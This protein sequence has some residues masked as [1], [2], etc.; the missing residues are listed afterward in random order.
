MLSKFQYRK[1][2]S[3]VKINV[4]E[5][6]RIQVTIQLQLG[7]LRRDCP[8]K[9][10]PWLHRHW[11]HNLAPIPG[12]LSDLGHFQTFQVYTCVQGSQST[13]MQKQRFKSLGLSKNLKPKLYILLL[14]ICLRFTRLHVFKSSCSAYNST[15]V[16]LSISLF[17]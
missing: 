9:S 8:W 11:L 12:S 13:F 4:C 17:S 6:R 14:K 5:P 2:N 10:P 1:S 3:G 7:C 15:S 16:L